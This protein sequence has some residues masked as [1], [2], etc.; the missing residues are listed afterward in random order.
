MT[1][2]AVKLI[3]GEDL[4]A[5]VIDK[6]LSGYVLKNPMRAILVNTQGKIAFAP[7]LLC[8]SINEATIRSEHVL[9]VVDAAMEAVNAYNV[10]VGNGIV[11]VK[12]DVLKLHGV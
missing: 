2:Q 1:I 7:W 12:E 8:A 10:T 11:V 5:D 6:G 4:I 3:N 9:C